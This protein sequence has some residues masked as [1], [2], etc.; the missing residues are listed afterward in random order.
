[1]G[2]LQY[3]D[4]T[5][6]EEVESIRV[7][8][9]SIPGIHDEMEKTATLD[10]AERK[11]RAASGTKRSYKMETRLVS[12]PSVRR[13][14]EGQLAE[15]EKVLNKL[16]D[17][18]KAAKNEMQRGQLFVGNRA[19]GEE[20]NAEADGDA[21]LKDAEHLQ[22]KTQ[23]S[24]DNT[25][26]MVAETKIVGMETMEELR[27]QRDQLNNI[28]QE[29]MRIED[30]LARADKLIRT[31]GRRMA[32]DKFIQC[33]AFVNVLLLVGVVI[34]AILKKNGLTGEEAVPAPT[35]PVRMLR[36]FSG[37]LEEPH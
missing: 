18:V 25:M 33:F 7:I 22:E 10:K 37:I 30:N 34:Y 16:A 28:D 20:P 12:D 5:L 11:L 19:D 27:R 26:N 4:D 9:G 14:Y 35:N 36:G 1:M 21:M 31:F 8:L 13:T 15:H 32:T 23:S 24:L 17:E 2:D 6:T 3:W 29:A